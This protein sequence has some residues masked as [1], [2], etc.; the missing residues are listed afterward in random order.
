ME[1]KNR[2]NMQA[3]KSLPKPAK[4]VYK[5]LSEVVL[6]Y[7][8]E[9]PSLLKSA[10]KIMQKWEK[11][12]NSLIKPLLTNTGIWSKSFDPIAL[13]G[14]YFI[15]PGVLHQIDGSEAFLFP[16][17][18]EANVA[19]RYSNITL[20]TIY[21]DGKKTPEYV[22][23]TDSFIREWQQAS[24]KTIGA[25]LCTN[26][27]L[28]YHSR[29]ETNVIQGEARWIF[30]GGLGIGRVEDGYCVFYRLQ[31]CRYLVTNGISEDLW[32]KWFETAWQ[33]Q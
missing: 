7:K 18:K 25:I 14:N 19:G 11:H 20:A 13:S 4:L 12:Y 9:S 15:I 31:Y 6:E 32:K 23:F 2:K 8:T 1:R 21:V 24:G 10:N 22:F 5:K 27:Y 3:N 29:I 28:A 16:I 17:T 30:H 33:M 26:L